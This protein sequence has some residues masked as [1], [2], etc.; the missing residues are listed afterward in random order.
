MPRF[1][2]CRAV[3]GEN[4]AIKWSGLA[5][6]IFILIAGYH[7]V[8]LSVEAIRGCNDDFDDKTGHDFPLQVPRTSVSRPDVSFCPNCH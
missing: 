5:A 3:Y 4:M 6:A 7:G 8:E 2:L 1:A